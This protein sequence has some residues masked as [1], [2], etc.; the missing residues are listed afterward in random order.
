MLLPNRHGSSTAYRYGFNGKEKDDELKGDG[1]SY[2]FGARM[3]DPRIGRWFAPDKMENKYPSFSTYNSFKNNPIFY[4]DPDGNDILPWKYYRNFFGFRF[5]PY[6]EMSEYFNSGEKFDKSHTQ[7]LSCSKIYRRVVNRLENSSRTYQFKTVH[8]ID[9]QYKYEN[10]K[11]FFDRNSK[12]TKEDPFTINLLVD[13]AENKTYSGNKG[14]IFEEVFHASQSDYALDKGYSL[15]SVQMEVE[16]KLI[17]NIEGIAKKEKGMIYEYMEFEGRDEIFSKLK[18]GSKLSPEQRETLQT[19][20]YNLEINI[21]SIP[22]Y[23]EQMKDEFF[24]A[25]TDL[26]YA[27]KLYGQKLTNESS[28]VTVTGEKEK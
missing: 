12:G 14:T 5:G 26:E 11:G 8:K 21:R 22:K 28:G 9:G 24:Y 6:Y 10:E 15:T 17:K 25:G 3:L 7:L 4:I 18:K 27:E 13:L 16:A 2:D 23:Q 1:N 20:I 19:A